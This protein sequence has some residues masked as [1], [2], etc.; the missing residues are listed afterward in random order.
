MVKGIQIIIKVLFLPVSVLGGECFG[1]HILPVNDKNFPVLK[2]NIGEI[3]ENGF[4]AI[5]KN[6]YL[7]KDGYSVY[8]KFIYEN[9]TATIFGGPY[10]EDKFQLAFMYFNW[11]N[12]HHTTINAFPMELHLVFYNR[13][14]ESVL[15]ASV[16]NYGITIWSFRYGKVC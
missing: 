12:K 16:E 10:G 4:S 5:P 3:H 11:L 2:I 9:I 13:I 8:I 15:K 1:K 6:V 7:A 14:Y